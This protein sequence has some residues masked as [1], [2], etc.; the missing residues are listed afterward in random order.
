MKDTLLVESV[1]WTN[2]RLSFNGLLLDYPVDRFECAI[3][4]MTNELHE[5]LN[6][7]R[8]PELFLEIQDITVGE[9]AGDI[10]NLKVG[11]H[12]TLTLAGVRKDLIVEDG[13]IENEGAD[14]MIFGGSQELLL[15]DFGLKPPT[16][17]LGLVKVR[18]D[19]KVSFRIAM[20]TRS[21]Q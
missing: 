13:Y 17:M 2:T 4:P 19:L 14:V 8:H 5:T 20:R 9:N 21:V 6:A 7:E 10:A 15:S 3:A 11:A 1:V 12:V 16:K 18:D